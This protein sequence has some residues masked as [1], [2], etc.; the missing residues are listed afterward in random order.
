[1]A[2]AKAQTPEEKK[3][4]EVAEKAMAD[5]DVR[6]IIAEPKI[7]QLLQNMQMGKSFEL[8]KEAARDPSIVQKLQKLAKAG[9]INM[10]W[11]P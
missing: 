8:H 3:A 10:Q 5:A 9:L 6:E 11:Q 7:Q 2:P 4:Q 1:M